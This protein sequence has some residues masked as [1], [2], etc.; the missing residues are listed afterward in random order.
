MKS[1]AHETRVAISMVDTRARKKSGSVN[2]VK[3]LLRTRSLSL[4]L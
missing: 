3:L 4:T 2:V 1:V